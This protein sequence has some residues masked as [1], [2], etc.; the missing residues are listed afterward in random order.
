LAL[1]MG[2]YVVVAKAQVELF[3]P[4]ALNTRVECMLLVGGAVADESAVQLPSGG[5]VATL[6]LSGVAEVTALGGADAV[7]KCQGTSV[8]AFR[9]KL[10]AIQVES[11]S[12]L[13]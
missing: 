10:T 7:L 2:K 8:F 6:P 1:P 9:V 13:P 11:L 4:E 3:D 5:G 12:S